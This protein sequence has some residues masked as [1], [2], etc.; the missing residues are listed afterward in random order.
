MRPP[1]FMLL[2]LILCLQASRLHAY[3]VT[4][5][6]ASYANGQI[7]L[8]WTNPPVNNLQYIVY[9]SSTPFSSSADL[10]ADKRL[11]FVRDSSAKNYHW[12]ILAKANVY[13]RITDGGPTLAPSQGL[14][15]TTCINNNSYYYAVTVLE[16]TT[17]VED[18]TIVAGQNC[19]TSP[20]AGTKTHP[21]P[22]F[23]QT[24]TTK[25]GEVKHHY[26]FFVD[27]Q[28]TDQFPALCNV[29]SYGFN[30]WYVKRGNA[31]S[32]PLFLQFEGSSDGSADKKL[33]L[34]SSWTNCYI[35]GLF[36]WLPTPN[37]NGGIG[38]SN[39]NFGWHENF[40]IYSNAN[41]IPTTGVV[42]TY[43]QQLY[44]EILEWAETHLP[45]DNKKVYARGSS[46]NGFGALLM[47]N[48]YSEKIAAVYAIVEPNSISSGTPVYKQ[49][50]G[51]VSTKLKT[52][53]V[54]FD[55]GDTLTYPDLKDQQ[56]MVH[57][58]EQRSMPPI[59]DIHGKNDVT[60]PWNSG[61]IRW[62]DSL[63]VNRI[64]GVRFWD[65]RDHTG[66]GK[67]FWES[68]TEPNYYR[69][70]T[71]IGYPA[72]SNCS[73]DHNPGDG[74]PA[75]GDP[76][77]AING[78]LDWKDST[79]KACK[80][81]VKVFIKDFYVGG[82]LHSQQYTTCTADITLRRCSNFKP[83]AGMT[84]KWSNTDANGVKIQK[85]TIS[86]YDGKLITIPNVIINKS[87]N[88]IKVKIQNCPYRLGEH[89]EEPDEEEVTQSVV[90][91]VP[92]SHGY[93]AYILSAQNEHAL[94]QVLDLSGR[95]VQ[96]QS[97]ALQEGMNEVEVSAP[98]GLHIFRLIAPSFSDSRKLFFH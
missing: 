11:G 64:G 1:L 61:R 86:N 32:Y 85:G 48:I 91:Y 72:F 95:I 38:I 39:Y 35:I 22:V 3:T 54:A 60:V 23:Q 92:I 14:Y 74:T 16:L 41:P 21:K 98:H 13:Y 27:N 52:D 28:A 79:D 97:L 26:V 4:N 90:S 67:N 20:V 80:F 50:W 78:Y 9:R 10:T 56:K 45:I 77:G 47:A 51:E 70:A 25:N 82:V 73:I 83:V 59:Y 94:V 33:S 81:W 71:N 34:D 40:N 29:G 88:L 55:T 30:F 84:L 65:Q 75:N 89:D 96:V 24:V 18:R 17:N 58:N 87:G 42:R 31:S 8:T 5:L 43:A 6:Q 44:R 49:M 36:D 12:S 76:Y 2:T 57:R 68:E 63:E 53:V 62:L 15:V 93:K 7:F 66:N 46:S 69:F 19:L 37:D